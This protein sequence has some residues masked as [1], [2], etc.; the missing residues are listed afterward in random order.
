LG[1]KGQLGL[2]N[3]SRS[4][5]QLDGGQIVCGQLRASDMTA[6]IDSD[7]EVM[8]DSEMPVIV[9]MDSE[10][11]TT[12][13][14]NGLGSGDGVSFGCSATLQLERADKMLIRVDSETL[15]TAVKGDA[16][17]EAIS[18]SWSASGRSGRGGKIR[19]ESGPVS[20]A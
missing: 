16:W 14:R 5:E 7:R 15:Q 6:E 8:I 2:G 20:G 17:L 3:T 9:V 18:L 19:G 11:V 4:N 10:G 12:T 13:D 1:T